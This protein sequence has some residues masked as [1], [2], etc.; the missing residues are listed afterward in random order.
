MRRRLARRARATA[1]LPHRVFRR[2]LLEASDGALGVVLAALLLLDDAVHESSL[3]ARVREHVDGRTLGAH[4]RELAPKKAD[5]AAPLKNRD[6]LRRLDARRRLA[7]L[8]PGTLEPR[9][10]AR[11]R[12]ARESFA[13]TERERRR[14]KDARG[15]AAK[16]RTA[17]RLGGAF[18][19]AAALDFEPRV[20]VFVVSTDRKALHERAFPAT[21]ATPMSAAAFAV[22]LTFAVFDATRFPRSARRRSISA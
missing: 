13:A 22:A 7:P 16:T 21:S 18:L 2:R 6:C 10:F 11:E 1:E 17:A 8:L 9:G 3:L 19:A 4:L 20:G 15:T 5:E 12:V 14:L